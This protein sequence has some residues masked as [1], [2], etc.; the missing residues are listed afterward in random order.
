MGH[1]ALDQHLV[2]Y[3]VGYAHLEYFADQPKAEVL[4]RLG[5]EASRWETV[6]A[7]GQAVLVDA[8]KL[9]DLATLSTYGMALEEKKRALAARRPTLADV[10]PMAFPSGDPPPPPSRL[11]QLM[12]S[13]PDFPPAAPQG[14]AE[15]RFT[16]ERYAI[17]RA[18]LIECAPELVDAVR[19]RHGLDE[20]ADLREVAA[21]RTRFANAPSLF[22]RY[23]A[24]FKHHRSRAA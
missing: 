15:P 12:A 21:W 22:E 24:L 18:E 1:R 7:Y 6:E 20:A 9:K 2:A 8:A 14:G 11:A 13:A 16:L 17:I 23:L 10:V 5:V 19:A 4:A 3:A